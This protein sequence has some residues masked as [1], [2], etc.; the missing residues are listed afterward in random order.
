MESWAKVPIVRET[1]RLYKGVYAA[2][3]SLGH[4]NEMVK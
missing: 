3:W 2:V 4:E 1:F